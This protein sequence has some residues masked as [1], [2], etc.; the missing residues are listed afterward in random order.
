[1]RITEINSNDEL[2][3][4]AISRFYYVEK[5]GTLSPPASVKSLRQHMH[6]TVTTA[7][8]EFT[9]MQVCQ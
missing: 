6:A 8:A 9:A 2:L 3:Q 1:M 5:I 4:F 7:R